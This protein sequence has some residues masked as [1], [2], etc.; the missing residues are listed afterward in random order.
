MDVQSE[1]GKISSSRL[2]IM[3]Q[4]DDDAMMWMD[5]GEEAEEATGETT[6]TKENDSERVSKLEAELARTRTELSDVRRELAA[7]VIVPMTSGDRMVTWTTVPHV[8]PLADCS[9]DTER[10]GRAPGEGPGDGCLCQQRKRPA[11][12]VC[13]R[14]GLAIGGGTGTKRRG[15]PE[16]SRPGIPLVCGIN[17]TVPA[18]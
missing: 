15:A 13:S 10:A 6:A 7:K 5:E 3:P 18:T 8:V 1:I 14:A 17:G 16:T 12:G 4:D 2:R 9:T 11:A